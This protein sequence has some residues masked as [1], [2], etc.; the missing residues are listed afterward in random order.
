MMCCNRQGKVLPV[1]QSILHKICDG[2]A[3]TTP[4]EADAEI[5]RFVATRPE[6]AH[7][8]RKSSSQGV[9]PLGS[10]PDLVIDSVESLIVQGGVDALT[11]RAVT[12]A[13]GF[14]NGSIYRTFGSRGGLVG[15]MWIRAERRFL[16][17]LTSL[18]DEAGNPLDAILA[19]AQAS[20]TYAEQYPQSA[21][22]LFTMDRAEA[23]SQPMPPAIADQLRVL[24]N[25]FDSILL[26]LSLDLWHRT[27]ADSIDLMAACV[28]D[29]PR[30]VAS[31]GRRYATPMVRDYLGGAVRAVLEVGP[32]SLTSDRELKAEEAIYRVLL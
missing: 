14:S 21:A 12:R 17:L 5:K 24:D 22:V 32:P 9:S 16:T 26:R 13:S 4:V 25:E 28:L 29:L 23:L 2:S 7:N 1:T 3:T 15:R 19:A 18:V 27:D 30:W 11:I 20:I 31:R 8:V 10:D 6:S